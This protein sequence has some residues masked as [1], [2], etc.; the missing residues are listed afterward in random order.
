M[1]M[2]GE[3]ISEVAGRWGGKPSGAKQAGTFLRAPLCQLSRKH[4]ALRWE[5]WETAKI[6]VR[7]NDSV[8]VMMWEWLC[9]LILKLFQPEDSS[10][11]L[12]LCSGAV[13]L[14]PTPS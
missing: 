13:L 3:G 4:G 11:L 12:R 8:S 14:S 10:H 1:G 7:I 2:Y 5:G 6:G 9:D